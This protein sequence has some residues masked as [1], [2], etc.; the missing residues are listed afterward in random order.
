MLEN[1]SPIAQPASSS[2]PAW[3]WWLAG[4]GCLLVLCSA[5]A[6]VAGVTIFRSNI[7]QLIT[8][9]IATLAPTE[10][11][12]GPIAT[13]APAKPTTSDGLPVNGNSMGDPNAPVKIIAY[14]DFQC[15]YCQQYWHDTEP[16]I[17]AT[18][19][20]TGKVYYELHFL[21]FLG[22]ESQDATKAAY[23]AA[24][25]GKFWEYHDILFTNL[26]GENVGSYSEARLHQYA[27]SVG[28]DVSAFSQCLQ[29]DTSLARI[30]ADKNSASQNNVNSTPSFLIN[31]QLMEGAQPFDAFKQIIEAAIPK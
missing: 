26:T 21:T 30:T 19:V 8:G 18:Y 2:R 6:L 16:Q 31:G 27:A 9:P 23:C 14:I 10:Q 17:I 5:V 13:V 28:L 24:D 3:I 25:Q 20:K 12:T 15:P 22:Q 29:S 4:C 7:E 1:N 11:Q